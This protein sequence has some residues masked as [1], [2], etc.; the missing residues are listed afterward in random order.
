[1]ISG[2]SKYKSLLEWLRKLLS[3][4][5]HFVI[6]QGAPY[7]LRWYLIPRN[8]FFNLYLHKFLRDDDDRALHDHPW[9]FISILLS[10]RYLELTDDATSPTGYR[11]IDRQ[12]GD[13]AYRPAT[14]RHRVILPMGIPCWTL[15]ITGPRSREWGFWCPKGFV[16]WKDFTSFEQTGNSGGIGRGCE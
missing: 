1:M 3:G 11:I 16:H 14:H 15:C 5:P 10:G 9:W 2:F 7:M 4:E 8:R 13:M 6:G 12:F